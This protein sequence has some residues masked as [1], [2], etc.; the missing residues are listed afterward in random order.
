MNRHLPEFTGHRLP[1]NNDWGDADRSWGK[2]WRTWYQVWTSPQHQG[3]YLI[4]AWQMQ[5]PEDEQP[6][7]PWSNL[8]LALPPHCKQLMSFR[9]QGRQA[10][11]RGSKFEFSKLIGCLGD[12]FTACNATRGIL[13]NKIMSFAKTMRQSEDVFRVFLLK[14]TSIISCTSYVLLLYVTRNLK[15]LFW[16]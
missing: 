6:A 13:M 1:T 8:Q 5:V 2:E 9:S 4:P 7:E 3:Q 10:R 12:S 11:A 15:C 16:L 14:V